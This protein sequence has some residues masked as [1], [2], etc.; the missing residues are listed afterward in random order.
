MPV[1]LAETG[2]GTFRGCVVRH[3]LFEE[4]GHM[5]FEELN[6]TALNIDAMLP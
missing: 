4:C 2:D 5:L 1:F 6:E 3:T